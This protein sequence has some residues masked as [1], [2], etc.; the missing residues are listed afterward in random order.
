MTNTTIATA[1]EM[2]INA[3]ITT[4][5]NI[6]A[7]V[8]DKNNGVTV[9]MLDEAL[10]DMMVAFKKKDTKA[11]KADFFARALEM[12]LDDYVLPESEAKYC[13]DCCGRVASLDEYGYCAECVADQ[14]KKTAEQ[15]AWAD[16][17]QSTGV[18]EITEEWAAQDRVKRALATKTHEEFMKDLKASMSS[19]GQ[20]QLEAAL[21]SA[22]EDRPVAET[23]LKEEVAMQDFSL[24]KFMKQEDLNYLSAERQFK[25]SLPTPSVAGRKDLGIYHEAAAHKDETALKDMLAEVNAQKDSYMDNLKRYEVVVD[26]VY[27][28]A[29]DYKSATAE[30]RKN[31]EIVKEIKLKTGNIMRVVGDVTVIIPKGFMLVKQWNK[32][33][34]NSKGELGAPDMVP[35]EGMDMNV[36]KKGFNMFIKP[37]DGTGK[38]VLS[39][40]EFV[41][42]KTDEVSPLSVFLP[43]EKD[44]K[45]GEKYPCF[46]TADA[47]F[48]KTKNADYVD[49][50][51]HLSD[52]NMNFNAMISAYVQMVAGEFMVANPENNH[53]SQKLCGNLIRFMQKDGVS[54]D[55]H[56][57]SKKTRYV[58]QQIDTTR[59]SRV[60]ANQPSN[61][62]PIHSFWVDGEVVE[63]FNEAEQFDR[64]TELM[65][66]NGNMRKP[67]FDEIMY[68]GRWMKKETIRESIVNKVCGACANYCGN[69]QK[70]QSQMN[71]DR[72]E[73]FDK[74]VKRKGKKAA[75]KAKEDGKIFVSPFVRETAKAKAQAFQTLTLVEGKEEWVSQFPYQVV[76]KGG[77]VL[78]MRVVGSGMMV[79]GSDDVEFDAEY[80]V[81]VEEKDERHAEVMKLIN[82]IWYASRNYSK[83]DAE[84]V[85][86]VANIV[87]NK[88]ELTAD[89]DRKWENAVHW[90]K[91]AIKRDFE[92]QARKEIVPFRIVF[93]IGPKKVKVRRATN[94]TVNGRDAYAVRMVD[95]PELHVEDIMGEAMERAA[96]GTLM[97]G[98]G[99][100]DLRPEEFT[101]YLDEVA[102][103]YVWNAILHGQ[104]YA[105]TG[106]TDKD[107]E[108]AAGAL[109][110][111][112]QRE[113]TGNFVAFVNGD[114]R[115]NSFATGIRRSE[116]PQAELD[117]FKLA[118]EIK[119]YLA[120]V[121]GLSK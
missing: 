28:Y 30:Q 23:K 13:K 58:Q 88:P 1:I 24:V 110:S 47:R 85:K 105:I 100:A 3:G 77:D 87:A 33:K 38:L 52:N 112:L 90:F 94:I 56:T 62:C 72:D 60:G 55:L 6:F 73:A 50:A 120:E 14:D 20:A 17:R 64:D 84:Q 67:R 76:A 108:L 35:F 89:E 69:Y 51:M 44:E 66:E 83:L 104:E 106:G 68:G 107:K 21:Q 95:A 46:H 82:H 99:Y 114:Y 115:D 54:D 101:R 81:P 63:I 18:T 49:Q 117:G 93:H 2:V 97:W 7:F 86:M 53:S 80:E 9:P 121:C 59:L 70:S 113:L 65:D 16:E 109:Q 71:R 27:F 8:M 12:D 26:E 5:A 34:V 39:I 15:V 57:E 37:A 29:E 78:D 98:L 41:D 96:E 10:V 48:I 42:A 22:A 4:A 103:T 19:N 74:L 116:N 92:A 43:T 118:P 61:W 36:A 79:Y 45:T 119:K 91:E 111:L 31:K 32:N 75:M 102:T 11:V 25:K 40:V